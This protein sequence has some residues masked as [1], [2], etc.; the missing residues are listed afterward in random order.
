ML[1]N[2]S[3]QAARRAPRE[4][5]TTYVQCASHPTVRASLSPTAGIPVKLML[6]GYEAAAALRA[7]R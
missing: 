5:R 6:L 4:P 3:A 7:T 2:R 1:K